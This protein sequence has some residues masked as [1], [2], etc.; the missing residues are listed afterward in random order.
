M[1]MKFADFRASLTQNAPPPALD[2]SLSALWWE[3]KGDWHK[4]HQCAQADEGANGAWVHAYLHRREGD[5]T[6][7]AHWYRRAGKEVAE[8]DL[9]DEWE[10]IA[11][12]LLTRR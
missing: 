7:A 9:A 12:A 1:S 8:S 3:A 5:L 10:T 11:R 4:A 6:N 2:H